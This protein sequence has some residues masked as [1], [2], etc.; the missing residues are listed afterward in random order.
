MRLLGTFLILSL[1]TVG[2]VPAQVPEVVGDVL[3]RYK[4]F[5]PG[6]DELAMYRIDWASSL[7]EAQRRALREKRPVFLVIIHAQYGDLSSGHC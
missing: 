6:K 5:R 2:N 7:E 3:D 1:A 4:A